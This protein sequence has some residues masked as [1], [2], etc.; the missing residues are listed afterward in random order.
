M[1]SKVRGKFTRFEGQIVT[2]DNPLDST[3]EATIQLDSID[4][5]QADRDAHI[6]SADF[7]EVETYPTMTYRSTAVRRSGDG[8]VVEGLL[9][10]H[11][12]TRPVELALELNGFAANTPMGSKAGFSASTEISRKDFGIEF[13]MPLDG[14][15]VVVGDKIQINLEIE[16]TLSA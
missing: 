5:S 12:V 10:L 8:F 11:G 4:T 16:A 13:N 15:G 6:R 1:V 7:F 2:A 9:D 3:V 14:G